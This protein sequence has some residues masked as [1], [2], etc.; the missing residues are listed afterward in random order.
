MHAMRVIEEN[1]PNVER[2]STIIRRVMEN[3]AC[4]NAMLKEKQQ[5]KKQQPITNFFRQR[6][7][8]QLTSESETGT[9]SEVDD[10]DDPA[11]PASPPTPHTHTE[12]ESG[13]E[14]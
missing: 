13:G 7:P 4:Y 10:P 2:S 8:S 1:D 3:M 12:S 11:A 5:K 6:T 9:D 14:A